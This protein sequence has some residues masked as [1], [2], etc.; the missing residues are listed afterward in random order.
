M[1]VILAVWET[2]IDWEDC[3]S[4]SALAKK[5]PRPHPNRKSWVWWY[6]FVVSVIMGSLK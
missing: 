6:A 2:E 5:F 3:S 1:S 4:R